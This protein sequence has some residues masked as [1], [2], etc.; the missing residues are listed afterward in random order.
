MIWGRLYITPDLRKIL[1]INSTD[2]FLIEGQDRQTVNPT[3]VP[4][5]F[6]I[7]YG[8]LKIKKYNILKGKSKKHNQEKKK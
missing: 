8:T 1:K 6:L 5:S 2:K 3:R 7:T 4:F